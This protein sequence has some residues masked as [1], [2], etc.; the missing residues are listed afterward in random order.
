M[1]YPLEIDSLPASKN[2]IYSCENQRRVPH[3]PLKMQFSTAP[4]DPFHSSAARYSN[5]CRMK[6]YFITTFDKQTIIGKKSLVLFLRYGL[7]TTGTK[8]GR[9]EQTE[10][11][12]VSPFHRLK[13][14]L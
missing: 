4:A 1:T 10:G 6:H 13:I 8:V 11:S 5:S 7:E 2:N 9:K 12:L 3:L 14:T